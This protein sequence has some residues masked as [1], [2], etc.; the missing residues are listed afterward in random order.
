MPTPALYAGVVSR[1][2]NCPEPQRLLMVLDPGATG[3]RCKLLHLYVPSELEGIAERALRLTSPGDQV[4]LQVDVAEGSLP[5]LTGF[6]NRSLE[7]L[8]SAD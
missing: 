1:L 7:A 4:E 6:R 3:V 5:R 8:C 2:S